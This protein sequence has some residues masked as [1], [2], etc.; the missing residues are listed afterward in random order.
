MNKPLNRRRS[1]QPDSS[2]VWKVNSPEESKALSELLNV[3]TW[4]LSTN[5][6]ASFNQEDIRSLFEAVRD[7]KITLEKIKSLDSNE[8]HDLIVGQLRLF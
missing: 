6:M 7:S 4:K 2:R 8:L 1:I 3:C 5:E